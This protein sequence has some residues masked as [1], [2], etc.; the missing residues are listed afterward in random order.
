MGRRTLAAF[1][2][3]AVVKTMSLNMPFSQSGLLKPTYQVASLFSGAGGLDAGFEATGCFKTVLANDI[4]KPAVE[5]F[6]ENF[7][8]PIAVVEKP[9]KNSAV[10]LASVEHVD[11]DALASSLKPDVLIGGPPCQD[12]SVVRGPS[13]DRQGIKVHRGRLYAHFV[14]ALVSFQPKVFVFENVPGLISANEGKAYNLILRDFSNLSTQWDEIKREVGNGRG[15]SIEGYDIVFSGIVDASKVGVPQA[16]R[17]LFVIGLRRDLA[18]SKLYD[19]AAFARFVLSGQENLLSKYPLTPMEAFEGKTLPDL[20]EKY[21]YI[22]GE[23]NGNLGGCSII[24]DY[25][26]LNGV[27][28]ATS[29]ELDDVFKEHEKVLKELG[30]L[31]RSLNGLEFPDGSNVIGRE[32]EAVLSRMR[33]IPPGSNHQHVRGTKWEVEGRGISLIY[34]RIHPLKPA[35]TVVAFGGGGTWGYHYERKRSKLTNRERARLQSFPDNFLFKGKIQEVRSQIG[36]AV[37]PLLA[38]RIAEVCQ[39]LLTQVCGV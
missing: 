32:D 33:Q 15:R 6:S 27:K 10:Y 39:F 30:Y 18:T 11:F 3:K 37:P 28:P 20:A 4:R 9:S 14:R 22:M 13:W 34:R 25:L 24:E 35:Y 38:K 16:R 31:G 1:T 19:M 23:W 17:R 7:G 2:R 29:A 12:F 5:T 26:A 36:E 8:L 21:R